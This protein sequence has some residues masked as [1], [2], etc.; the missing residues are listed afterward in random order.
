MV[1]PLKIKALEW[2]VRD[3][4][5]RRGRNSEALDINELVELVN[6]TDDY[7]RW[8]EDEANERLFEAEHEFPVGREA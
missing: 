3:L 1:N 2:A 4:K 5:Q 8:L 7:Y 6:L